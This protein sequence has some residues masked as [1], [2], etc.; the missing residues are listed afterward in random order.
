MKKCKIQGQ[1]TTLRMPFT[2]N[3]KSTNFSSTHVRI[4]VRERHA[5]DISY[6]FALCC[7]AV[8]YAIFAM[9]PYY[10]L[11][12]FTKMSRWKSCRLYNMRSVCEPFFVQRNCGMVIELSYVCFW[13]LQVYPVT[14]A[15]TFLLLFGCYE[16]FILMSLLWSCQ[17]LLCYNLCKTAI[18]ATYSKLCHFWNVRCFFPGRFLA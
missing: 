5:S 2:Y 17:N 3:R 13:E 18:F 9:L 6:V 4:C 1:V 7:S 10:K 16:L 14:N 15:R 11:L 12:K 8:K